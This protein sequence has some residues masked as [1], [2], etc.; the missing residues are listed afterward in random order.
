MAKTD[1]EMLD[2][3]KA[4][5]KR[6][7]NAIKENYDRVSATLPL[8]TIDRIKALGLTINGVINDSVLAFLECA[9][10]SVD[11]P[12]SQECVQSVQNAETKQEQTETRKSIKEPEKSEIKANTMPQQD[13]KTEEEKI[14]EL[15]AVI[16]EK[17]AKEERRKAEKEAEKERQKQKE[18]E[19]LADGIRKLQQEQKER[20]EKELAENKEKFEQFDEDKLKAMLSDKEFRNCVSNPVYKADFIQNYGICNYERVQRCLREIEGDE[21]ETARKENIASSNCPF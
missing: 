7:N 8:G 20:K 11:E 1:Q 3:Y 15:Q 19:E 2:K 21:R 17:R 13:E 10:E 18:A 6:Q 14:A 12:P 5:I 4:R 9:E 16:D